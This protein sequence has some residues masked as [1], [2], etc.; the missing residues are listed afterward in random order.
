MSRKRNADDYTLLSIKV[1]KYEVDVGESININLRTTV[2]YS[3]DDT[4]PVVA[5][6]LRVEI[7]GSCTYPEQ[8]AGDS[9]ELTLY[10]EKL[11]R[12]HLRFEHIRVRDK[13][14]V[15]VYRKYRGQDYPLFK[16]P[17]GL[18]T[19]ERRRGTREWHAALF[20]GAPTIGRMLT[21]LSL[22]RDLYVSIDEHKIDRQRWV[23]GF[24][25]QTTDPAEE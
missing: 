25:L 12:D 4:D 10:G 9:Y 2:P 6:D 7:V 20:L 14:N 18:A 22:R 17:S 13:H 15:P 19:V 8:R 23:R 21:V 5:P 11:A 1:T 24:S 16:V 3:W